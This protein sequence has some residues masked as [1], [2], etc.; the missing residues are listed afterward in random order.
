MITDE[1]FKALAKRCSLCEEAIEI[2]DEILS[3]L[4]EAV[5]MISRRLTWLGAT[6]EDSAF[7]KEKKPRVLPSGITPGDATGVWRMALEHS[8]TEDERLE[9]MRRLTIVQTIRKN[10]LDRLARKKTIEAKQGY[11][12]PKI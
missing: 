8:C 10:R 9:L 2:Q 1:Q 3:G 4:V 12:R 5:R 11:A 6:A 7:L